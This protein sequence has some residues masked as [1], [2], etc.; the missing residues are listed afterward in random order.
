MMKRS[1]VLV[2]GL[3]FVVSACATKQYGRVQGISEAERQ[4]YSCRDIILEMEKVKAFEN[5]IE[6]TGA[7][8]WRTVAGFLGDF[9]IGNG[10]AKDEARASA[11][12]RR[13]DLEGLWI[14]KACTGNLELPIVANSDDENESGSNR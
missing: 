10:M 4:M 3:S 5:Q 13:T 9:G 6:D 1:I 7:T 2:V 12:L 8:D 14:R 11:R